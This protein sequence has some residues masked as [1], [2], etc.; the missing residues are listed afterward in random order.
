M[1][2]RFVRLFVCLFCCWLSA[3]FTRALLHSF[4]FLHLLIQSV[5]SFFWQSV[6]LFIQSSPSTLIFS[7]SNVYQFLHALVPKFLTCFV[8]QCVLIPSLLCSSVAS[9]DSTCVLLCFV[10]LSVRLSFVCAFV[11]SLV[12][13]FHFHLLVLLF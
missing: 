2:V 11:H 1:F 6:R 10:G 8:H 9:S 12:P 5:P 4:S 7:C 3:M 13:S